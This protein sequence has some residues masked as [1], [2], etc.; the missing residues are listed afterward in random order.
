M[1]FTAVVMGC[2]SSLVPGP[3]GKNQIFGTEAR[4]KANVSVFGRHN[5]TVCNS[6]VPRLF[7]PTCAQLPVSRTE[8]SFP[9]L[10]TESNPCCN[11]FESETETVDNL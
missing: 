10:D 11:G 5:S 7:H 8:S 3:H 4:N 1:L 9:E 6:L 2:H